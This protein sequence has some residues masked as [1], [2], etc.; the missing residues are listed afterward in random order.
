MG[1]LVVAGQHGVRG[2]SSITAL[3][4]L[5]K[6]LDLF[7]AV[8]RRSTCARAHS[9]LS[10]TRIIK[11]GKKRTNPALVVISLCIEVVGELFYDGSVVLRRRIK[12]EDRHNPS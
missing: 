7:T 1:F 6:Y 10:C 5:S 8:T 3:R 4:R 9:G 11:E 12:I 2:L